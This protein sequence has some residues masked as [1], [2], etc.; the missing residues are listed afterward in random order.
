M[1][2]WR[3]EYECG[4]AFADRQHRGLLTLCGGRAALLHA[5]STHFS[6]ELAWMGES[7]YPSQAEQAAS[8]AV[9]QAALSAPSLA[10]DRVRELLLQHIEGQ[11]RKMRVHAD[12]VRSE[13]PSRPDVKGMA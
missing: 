12:R 3:P 10:P 2:P 11:V 7:S 9:L 6:E 5:L 1:D 8:N 13:R 4:L